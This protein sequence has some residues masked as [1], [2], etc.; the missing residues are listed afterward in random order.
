MYLF[1]GTPL[2][3]VSAEDDFAII[4]D[5]SFTYDII[6]S[7]IDVSVNRNDFSIDTF[8]VAGYQFSTSQ[9]IEI[10]VTYVE[11]EALNYS[12]TCDDVTFNTSL[13]VSSIGFEAWASMFFYKF[14]TES[15]FIPKSFQGSYSS[16]GTLSQGSYSSGFPLNYN[17]LYF[18]PPKISTW[19]FLQEIS[20]RQSTNPYFYSQSTPVSEKY[21]DLILNSS[22]S[23][24]N[25]LVILE[26]YVY[27][28]LIEFEIEGIINN[29]CSYAFNKTNGVL[30]GLRSIGYFDGEISGYKVHCESEFHM[31]LSGFDLSDHSF[32]SGID[33]IDPVRTAIIFIGIFSTLLIVPIIAISIRKRRN[34]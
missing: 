10:N 1:V 9:S 23:E 34:I 14:S 22:Y 13:Y 2:V 28:Y 8:H 24:Q 20:Q 5:Q 18:I 19:D 32:Y 27:A 7:K 25:D 6:T 12:I 15:V 11:L 4:D 21:G 26:N 29:G 31:E 30:Y 3:F 33:Y 17:I 16:Y